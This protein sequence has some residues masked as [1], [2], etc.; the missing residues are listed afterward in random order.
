MKDKALIWQRHIQ[1]QQTSTLTV[2]AYCDQH[3]LSSGMFHYW[4]RKLKHPPESSQF[5]EVHLPDPP[6]SLSAIHLRFPSG[7]EMWLDGHTS[8]LFLKS[9]VGC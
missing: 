4:K 9:L 8:A 3:D 6:V 1:K 2:Q 7:V 5:E